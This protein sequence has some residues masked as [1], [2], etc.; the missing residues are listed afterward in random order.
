MRRDDYVVKSMRFIIVAILQRKLN[1]WLWIKLLALFFFKLLVATKTI[2]TNIRE[3]LINKNNYEEDYDDN[4]CGSD[5]VSR[6]F[7]TE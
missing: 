2:I 3:L 1:R 4:G 5:D 6:S 7:R